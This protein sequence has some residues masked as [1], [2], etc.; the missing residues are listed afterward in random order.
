MQIRLTPLGA[1]HGREADGW[2]LAAAILESRSSLYPTDWKA[3]AR[4]NRPG[5][6][7]GFGVGADGRREGPALRSDGV[8]TQLVSRS[9]VV[10]DAVAAPDHGVFFPAGRPGKPQAG[11]EIVLVKSNRML[12][13]DYAT[14]RAARIEDV[15]K[16][17]IFRTTRRT[18]PG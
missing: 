9:L 5:I 1:K 7:I 6:W 3:G 2:V 11:R 18:V 10:E 4:A 14:A 16:P 8:P 12:V 17:V 15:Q 13:E